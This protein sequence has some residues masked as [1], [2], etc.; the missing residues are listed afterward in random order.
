MKSP[1]V[2]ISLSDWN[3]TVVLVQPVGI[4]E[5]QSDEAATQT[6]TSSAIILVR[7]TVEHN[8][9]VRSDHKCLQL[10]C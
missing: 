8:I 4:P 7:T 3:H 10:G 1:E 9:L 2:M 6:G 5:F